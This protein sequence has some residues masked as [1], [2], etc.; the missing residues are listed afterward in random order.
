MSVMH[1]GNRAENERGKST[2]EG[3]EVV[4][5]E[6]KEELEQ[7]VAAAAAPTK[8]KVVTLAGVIF[9]YF[10]IFYLAFFLACSLLHSLPTFPLPLPH[11]GSTNTTT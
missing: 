5:A 8:N 10:L 1:W 3:E 11:P 7:D 4:T 9:Y 6:G 2:K